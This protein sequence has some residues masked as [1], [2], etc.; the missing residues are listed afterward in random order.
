MNFN[1]KNREVLLKL[2]KTAIKGRDRCGGTLL[3]I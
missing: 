3:E 2:Y 1:V